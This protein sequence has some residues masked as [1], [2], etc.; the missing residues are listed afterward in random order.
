MISVIIPVYNVEQYLNSCINSVISQS[1]TDFEIILVDDGSTDSSGKMCDEWSKKDSRIKVF[2]KPNGGLSSA[3]NYGIERAS[4]EYI[5]FLDSDD[6]ISETFFSELIS[7]FSNNPQI[8]VSAC[9]IKTFID[10]K[11]EYKDF[12]P[13]ESG[14]FSN[15]NFVSGILAHRISN[16]V[17][18]KIYKRSIIDSLRFKDGI[19]N[20]D[21]PFVVELFSKVKHIASTNRCTYYYRLRPGSITR[22]LHP[23]CCDFVENAYWAQNFIPVHYNHVNDKLI[24]SYIFQEMIGVVGNI[25]KYNYPENTIEAYNKYRKI[26]K[27]NFFKILFDK[28][29]A[30]RQRQKL[31]ILFT[32]PYL[33]QK[34]R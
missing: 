18:N 14:L 27:R 20:E 5:S 7:L 25:A 32:L 19:I 21:F 22:Q 28:N 15:D 13:C 2:H 9:G 23:R 4:G 24:D 8:D 30:I 1:Y 33:M 26:L 17:W 10:G 11:N 29:I 34:R 16:A 31:L 3:R 6:F 12:M